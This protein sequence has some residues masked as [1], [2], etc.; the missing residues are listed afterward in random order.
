MYSAF[1]FDAHKYSLR[2]RPLSDSFWAFLFP[3][4][5]FVPSV[6]DRS[7]LSD[8]GAEEIP[9]DSQL[10]QRVLWIALM[11]VLGWSLIGLAGALPLYLVN[12]PCL[13]N[14][15]PQAS[16]GGLYS[17][18]QDLSLLRLLQLIPNN[19]GSFSGKT[20]V[21][22]VQDGEGVP[23]NIRI[24]II[25]L[26]VFVI[27]L[28]MLPALYKLMKEFTR[29]ANY[30]KH[31]LEIRCE[32]MDLGW[33]SARDAP[34]F[35]GWG[36]KQIKDFIIKSGLSM[37]LDRSGGIGVSGSMAGVGSGFRARTQSQRSRNRDEAERPLNDNEKARPEIDVT[38]L[39]SIR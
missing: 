2:P 35:V 39:F 1:L 22:R 31:W 21:K 23:K 13:A 8:A 10:S 28:A 9:S 11:I 20:L 36:E 18:L 4:V 37:S 33:L 30:R 6:P 3:H 12:T 38:G 17:T 24:R 34:G 27:V 7:D 26:T 5:P 16:F 15:T 19:D 32:E 25:I 14:S 29:L